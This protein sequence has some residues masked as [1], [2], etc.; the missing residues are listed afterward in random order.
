VNERVRRLREQSINTK[1]YITPERAILITEFYGSDVARL[2]STPVKRA[3]AFKHLL[4]NKRVYIG[5]G[6]L[7][8]GERGPVPKA[9]PTYPEICCHSLEDLEILSIRKRTPY[10]VDEET[11]RVYK[12]KIIP[13]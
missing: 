8:V 9:V 5:E 2:L 4:E 7:I 10:A 6:E 11:K 3:R 1:P 12:E 13:F